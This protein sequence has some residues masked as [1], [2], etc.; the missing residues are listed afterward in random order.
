MLY[1]IVTVIG[2]LAVGLLVWRLVQRQ[3]KESR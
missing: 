3:D 2:M 1:S